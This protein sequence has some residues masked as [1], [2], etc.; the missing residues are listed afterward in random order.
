[1]N[2]NKETWKN[3]ILESIRD[4]QKAEPSEEVYQKIL[5]KIENSPAENRLF[6]SLIPQVRMMAAAGVLLFALN[7]WAA[8]QYLQ[9]SKENTS[10]NVN[11]SYDF[12]LYEK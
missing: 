5:A 7:S 10:Y 8:Y 3:R 11:L 4:I 2:T 9:S 1:M 12:N 6:I